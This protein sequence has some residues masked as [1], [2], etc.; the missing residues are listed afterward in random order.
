M[1]PT[2]VEYMAS[3]LIDSI[4][5][6]LSFSLTNPHQLSLSRHTI[7]FHQNMDLSPFSFLEE[8]ETGGGGGRDSK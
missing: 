8:E 2:T 1:L 3:L 5:W 6:I 7:L 4:V